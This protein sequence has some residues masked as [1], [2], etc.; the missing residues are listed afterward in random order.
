MEISKNTIRVT[1]SHAGPDWVFECHAT[2]PDLGAKVARAMIEDMERQIKG[3]TRVRV[4]MDVG[5]GPQLFD[6]SSPF[7][8][9]WGAM[10]TA[11]V[12]GAIRAARLSFGR[13]DRAIQEDPDDDTGPESVRLSPSL[14]LTA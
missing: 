11:R 1:V 5:S 8:L 3:A 2:G 9:P 6:L 10:M 7:A 14:S 4:D 13:N 12:C